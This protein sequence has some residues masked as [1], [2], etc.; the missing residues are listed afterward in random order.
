MLITPAKEE[1]NRIVERTAG[2]LKQALKVHIAS[3]H[4]KGLT[5]QGLYLKLWNDIQHEL[6]KFSHTFWKAPHKIIR[7][8]IRARFGGLYTQKLGCRY[9]HAHD[10]SCPLCG[11]PD[12]AGH[13][14]GEC[15]YKDMKSL[16][17]ERCF[18]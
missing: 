2:N 3:R 13:I 15:M 7:N 12:S 6:H 18:V 5:K 11:L 14:L 8:V 17:I 1:V 4:A 9:R 10:D 16:A